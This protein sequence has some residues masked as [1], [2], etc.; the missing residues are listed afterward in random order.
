MYKNDHYHPSI[1]YSNQH[2][3]LTQ[4]LILLSRKMDAGLLLAL[5]LLAFEIFN[6]SATSYALSDL[7]GEISF[8][9]IRWATI[10]AIAFCAI[11][12]A[13]LLR[14]FSLG[15]GKSAVTEAWYLMGAWLL[16]ATMN[17]LTAWWAVSVIVVNNPDFLGQ[18]PFLD[19]LPFLVA[20]LIWLTRLLFIGAF[21]LTAG[22]LFDPVNNGLN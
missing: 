22:H 20:I 4:K 12:A 21:G 7:L 1:V 2:Q 5:A 16:G 8:I 17:A 13:G 9:G 6:F 19:Y 15:Q 18:L 14:F 11:D 3:G 10:L